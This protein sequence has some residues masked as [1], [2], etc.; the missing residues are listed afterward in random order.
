MDSNERITITSIPTPVLSE[1]AA[2][3]DVIILPELA[4]LGSGSHVYASTSISLKKY[5][6]T[7]VE[8]DFLTP[9]DDLY[10]QRSS[11]IYLPPIL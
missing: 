9:M 7:Q 5:A 2:K 11:A 4:S 6:E 1:T 3:K 8:I 10:E